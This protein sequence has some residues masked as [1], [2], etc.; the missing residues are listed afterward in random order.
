VLRTRIIAKRKTQRVGPANKPERRRQRPL[1][2]RSGNLNIG[3]ERKADVAPE[4]RLRF[5]GKYFHCSAGQ[6]PCARSYDPYTNPRRARGR[7]AGGRQICEIGKRLGVRE[8]PNQVLSLKC[9]RSGTRKLCVTLNGHRK[10]TFAPARP[11]AIGLFAG[12]FVATCQP[13]SAPKIE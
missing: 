12:R 9:D 6:L 13:S 5:A 4:K 7:C 1:C 3:I 8:P 2:D 11:R 10:L